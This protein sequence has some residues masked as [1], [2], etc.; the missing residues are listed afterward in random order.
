MGEF[1]ANTDQVTSHELPSKI[2]RVSV[3]IPAHNEENRLPV[4]ITELQKQAQELGETTVDIVVAN[5]GSKDDTAHVAEQNGAIVDSTSIP[6]SVGSARKHGVEQALRLSETSD[7]S[8]QVLIFLDADTVPQ[9]GYLKAVLKAFQEDPSLMVSHG[10][11]DYAFSNGK[12]IRRPRFI[13]RIELRQL[14]SR[15]GLRFKDYVPKPYEY[16]PGHNM[17]VRASAYLETSGFHDTDTTAEDVR[18]SLELKRLLSAEAI[19]YNPDQVVTTSGRNYEVSP[20]KISLRKVWQTYRQGHSPHQGGYGKEDAANGVIQ[21][22]VS[23][24]GPLH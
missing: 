7:S 1:Y 3:I 15:L 5:N 12:S 14:F 23:Q 8:Q 4:V 11:V 22:F 16:F 6:G 9:P 13:R 20:G 10:P 17:A 18:L 2:G 24:F 21:S 19:H